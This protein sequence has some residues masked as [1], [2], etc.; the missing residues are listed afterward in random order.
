MRFADY[1]GRAFSDVSASQ[2]PWLKFLRES[3]VAKYA[4]VSW[5]ERCVAS[6]TFYLQ[7]F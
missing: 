4:D 7:L 3:A 6:L 5:L 1:F 2:F